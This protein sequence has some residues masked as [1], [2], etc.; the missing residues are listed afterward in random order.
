MIER[1]ARNYFGL[2][3][4]TLRLLL[5]MQGHRNDR[6]RPGR[7]LR[8]ERGDYIRQHAPQNRRDGSNLVESQ[9]MYQIAESAVITA[10]SHRP[11]ERRMSLSTQTAARRPGIETS[12]KVRSFSADA[13]ESSGQR[14][15]LV[16]AVFT[17]WK[18]GNFNQW[19]ATNAA[20]GG[21][22]SK[23]ETGSNALCPASDRSGRSCGLGSPYSKPGT[24]EDALPHP[25]Y[26]A[27][28]PD[29][30]ASI[31]P[32][33]ELRNVRPL[34]AGCWPRCARRICGRSPLE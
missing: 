3:E 6:D 17:N 2:I 28:A 24:A 10:I 33:S 18:L 14:P 8:L 7:Q 25:E 1:R 27:A 32:V 4:S 34:L 15:G 23:E 16:H 31:S 29:D 30:K 5:P 9:K 19:G 11:I 13:A 12:R 22:K 26:G 21:K 20:I